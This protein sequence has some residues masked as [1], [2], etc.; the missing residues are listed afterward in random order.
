[1]ANNSNYAIVNP[2]DTEDHYEGTDVPG[3]FRGL[4]GALGCG[5]LA[6]TLRRVAAPADFAQGTRH[7]PGENAEPHLLPRG[8]VPNAFGAGNRPV[9]RAGGRARRGQDA[10]LAPQRGR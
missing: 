2:D 1:M 5:Q 4:T 9:P 3:E 7:F 8:T 10:P 6:V